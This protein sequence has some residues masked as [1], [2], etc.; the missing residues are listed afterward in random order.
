VSKDNNFKTVSAPLLKLGDEFKVYEPQIQQKEEEKRIEQVIIP[1]THQVKE[2]PPVNFSFFNPEKHE[3]HTIT[4]GPM[5]IKVTKYP[6]QQPLQTHKQPTNPIFQE[7][8]IETLGSDIPYIKGSSGKLRKK[9]SPLYQDPRFLLFQIL[10]LLIAS[11]IIYIHK[12]RQ[13]LRTDIN[14]ARKLSAPR[15]A[16]KGINRTRQFLKQGK[17]QQFYDTLFKTLQ[18]YLGEK[19][20]LPSAG[21]T[22]D[23][24]DEI[25]KPK[26]ID[27]QIV[28]KIKNIF[29][30]CDTA[31]YSMAAQDKKQMQET[32]KNI[33]EVIDYLQK[34]KK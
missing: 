20:S 16:K 10:P 18:H 33:Q 6:G 3:Y 25:L 4:C 5:P 8:R 12:R 7:Q 11:L 15:K 17:T 21:I 30:Q 31:R 32:L 23:F 14:Y 1:R 19:F 9:N 24:V 26:K 22:L 27:Q 2:I 28:D 29:E 34:Y 13:R